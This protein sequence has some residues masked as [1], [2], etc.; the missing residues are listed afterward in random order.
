MSENK[1][2]DILHGI[3]GKHT[4]EEIQAQYFEAFGRFLT[5][6]AKVEGMVRAFLHHI[7]NIKPLILQALTG[8]TRLSDIIPPIKKISELNSLNENGKKELDTVFNHLNL[9]TVLRDKL[10]HRGA[11]VKDGQ[12]LSTNFLS[13]KAIENYEEIRFDV[14][15]LNNATSDLGAILL[16]LYALMNPND[17]T[18][19]ELTELGV[20]GPWKYKSLKPKNP[21]QPPLKGRQKRARLRGPSRP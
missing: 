11:E 1:L 9:I 14:K 13:L 12:L 4:D 16:R 21:N 5:A 20:F 7:S 18:V 17:P 10:V 19:S 15:D 3:P 6:Y 2:I 8:G